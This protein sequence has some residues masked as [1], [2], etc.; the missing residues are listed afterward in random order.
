MLEAFRKSNFF[1]FD[2]CKVLVNHD[3]LEKVLKL[4]WVVLKSL[5]HRKEKCIHWINF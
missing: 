5:H 1:I 4:L 2:N 3:Q